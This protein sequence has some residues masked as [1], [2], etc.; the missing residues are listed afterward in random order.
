MSKREYWQVFRAPLALAVLSL[1]GLLSALLGDG[2]A[3]LLSWCA[4]GVVVGVALAY[5]APSPAPEAHHITAP[6]CQ[7]KNSSLP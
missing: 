2:L 5:R 6:T 1:V 4:L 7:G 3:D